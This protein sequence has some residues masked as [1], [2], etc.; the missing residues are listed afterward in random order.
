MA[1]VINLKWEYRHEF[2]VSDKDATKILNELGNDG[3]EC[4]AVNFSDVGIQCLL[5]RAFVDNNS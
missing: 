1:Q 2:I 5:K 3:W 4:F